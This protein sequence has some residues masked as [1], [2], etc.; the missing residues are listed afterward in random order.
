MREKGSEW[1]SEWVKKWSIQ[2]DTWIDGWIGEFMSVK[3][4]ER[5]LYSITQIREKKM[6]A[7]SLRRCQEMRWTEVKTKTYHQLTLYSSHIHNLFLLC[8]FWSFRNTPGCFSVIGKLTTHLNTVLTKQ[9]PRLAGPCIR[10]LREVVA[11]PL[12]TA[13]FSPLDGCPFV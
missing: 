6:T 2:I 12:H 3:R 5:L 1:M 13:P 9:R 10:V 4:E 11:A 8:H 7:F